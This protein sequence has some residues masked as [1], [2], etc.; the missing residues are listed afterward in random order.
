MPALITY[1][2]KECRYLFT[3]RAYEQ[4]F[5]IDRNAVIGRRFEDVLPVKQAEER[6]PWVNRALSGE[7]VSFEVSMRVSE[8]MRYM[9]VTYTPH[10]GDSQAILGF[11]A[12]YQDITK[13][14]RRRLPLKRP[15]KPAIH[16]TV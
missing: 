3:N 16:C 9:L 2:D 5:N 10:F 12:L 1:F 4:A 13:R 6:A 14:R 11:F 15:T 7:R 8:A